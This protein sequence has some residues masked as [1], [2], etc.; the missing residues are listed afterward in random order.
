[1]GGMD[2]CV[3]IGDM[4]NCTAL[5]SRSVHSARSRLQGDNAKFQGLRR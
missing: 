4:T 1:M 3:G 5:K 2:D